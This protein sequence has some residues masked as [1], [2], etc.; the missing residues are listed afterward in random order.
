MS[1]KV[2]INDLTLAKMDDSL[3]R[4]LFLETRSKIYQERS[5]KRNKRVLKRLEID[6][7]YVQREMSIRH[8]RKLFAKKLHEGFSSHKR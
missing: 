7:C 5:N 4:Q 8:G 1:M 3:L 6:L 2:I